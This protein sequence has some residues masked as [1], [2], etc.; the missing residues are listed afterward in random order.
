MMK[1]LPKIRAT[2]AVKLYSYGLSQK[3]IAKL[4]EVS[5]AEISNYLRAKRGKLLNIRIIDEIAKEIYET[6]RSLSEVLCKYCPKIIN[7]V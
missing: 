5:Q 1:L 7:L 2:L 3:E 4:L 6:K